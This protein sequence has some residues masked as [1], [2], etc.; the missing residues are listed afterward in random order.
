VAAGAAAR[1][2]W[3]LV[4]HPPLDYV[5]SDMAGY[6]G[7]AMR[8]ASTGGL[9]RLDSFFPPGTHLLL[10]EVLEVFGADRH[11]LWAGAVVW[12]AASSAIPIFVWRLA[13]VLLTPAAAALAAVFTAAWP[14]LLTNAGYFLSETPSLA[15]LVAC[16]WA[17]YRAVEI[18]GR[19]G[20]LLAAAAGI[21]GAASVT[22]RPQ[23]ILNLAV[24]AFPWLLRRRFALVGAVAAGFVAIVSA[25]LVHNSL[26]AGKPTGLSENSGVTFFIGHCDAHL[27]RTGLNLERPYFAGSPVAFQLHRGRDYVFPNRNIWDEGF[28]YDRGLDCIS[29][30]GAR[31]LELVGRSLVDLTYTSVLW[32]QSL[33]PRLHAVVNVANLAYCAALPLILGGALTL[34]R[35]RRRAGEVSG[36]AL[37]LAHL[38]VALVPA[39]VFFGDP[40]FRMPY[41][42]FGLTLLAAV[43]AH[44]FF[45]PRPGTATQ[46]G[47]IAGTSR[48]PA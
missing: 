12:A 17:A 18:G 41:D 2:V 43:V 21:L 37:V 3:I 19:W 22:M 45:D 15:F 32:P 24:V 40:R 26:A 16:L 20:I 33:E 13:R 30:D 35:R 8:L 44:V 7:R 42:V 14:L 23:F 36:E 47:R 29:D 25:V 46:A 1:F 10:A 6:V 27:V 11:G 28:F 48:V 4:F 31:H 9:D 5:S 38:A 34:I 39:V